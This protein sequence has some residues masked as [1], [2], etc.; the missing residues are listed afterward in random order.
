MDVRVLVDQ[1]NQ[2]TGQDK[3]RQT[4]I[5]R[6][7]PRLIECSIGEQ[8]MEFLIDSGAK[9]NT[10]SPEAYDRLLKYGRH[11]IVDHKAE[12]NDELRSYAASRPLKVICT[13]KADLSVPGSKRTARETEFYVIEG[14]SVSLLSFETSTELKLLRVG[15]EVFSVEKAE[16][17]QEF[18]KM[19]IPPIKIRT[20]NSQEP[21][22][23]YRYNIPL[24]MEAGVREKIREM[25]RNGI[26][27][28][29]EDPTWIS[30]MH[31]VPKGEDGF[32]ITIDYRDLN[33]TIPRDPFPMPITD[34]IMDK[35]RKAKK[36]SKYDL[37][38]AYHHIVLHRK[39]RK[40][41]AFM[42]DMG[43]MQWTRLP[44]GLSCAPELFQMIMENLFR[45]VEGVAVFLDDIL[46]YA[47]NIE[48]LRQR[49]E[50]VLE[51]IK[52][53]NLTLNQDKCEFE[54]DSIE[55]LGFKVDKDGFNP[56]DDKIK[57]VEAF[58]P[59]KSKK[60]LRSFLGLV[61]FLS[62]FI[63]NLSTMT[64]P[65]R[66]LLPK[67]EK[68]LW[69]SDQT[70]AFDEIKK[71]VATDIKKRGI[72][73]PALATELVTDASPVGLGAMLVQTAE[74]NE[75]RLIACASK[76][77]T[78]TE[79]KYPQT[80]REALAVVW[81]VEKFRYYL[82][83][84]NFTIVTDHEA[85]KFI[86]GKEARS[87]PGQI[88]S[89]AEGWALRLA[90]Y[91]FK[92]EFVA[93]EL[94]IA[95][96]AS[97]L[98]SQTDSESFDKAKS[99]HELFAVNLEKETQQKWLA[100]TWEQIFRA[101]ESDQEMALIA[102]SLEGN[103]RAWPEEI[104]KY[105]AFQDQ[106]AVREDGLIMKQEKLLLPKGLRTSAI[107]NAHTGHAGMSKMKNL[108]RKQVWWLGMDREVEEFV[109]KCVA[110]Q[111]TAGLPRPEPIEL[112]D[113]PEKPWDY[114]AI[115][116][117]SPDMSRHILVVTDC[118]S[119][120]LITVP[121]RK[122]DTEATKNVLN[123]IF[124]TYGLPK[125]I[126]SDNGAPFNAVELEEWL[127]R[128]GIKLI[129]STPW[130]PTENGLVERQNQGIK[131]ALR[132]AE[133]EKVCWEEALRTYTSA[134]NGWI[135]DTTLT[136]P[137]ELFFGRPL[138]GWLPHMTSEKE[139]KEDGEIRDNDRVKKFL[140]NMY[141]DK[142]RRARNSNIKVGDAVLVWNTRLR[143]GK[144]GF[145]S[146]KFKVVKREGGRL[147]VRDENG[148]EWIRSTKHA[149]KS[150]AEEKPEKSE[151]EAQDEPG[152]T[153]KKHWK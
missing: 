117:H 148:A 103:Q 73:D 22:Q 5:R 127:K 6:H 141:Q 39:S 136:A 84:L 42:T 78:G 137:S 138:R 153:S 97:R 75:K 121:M 62:P 12:V 96:P 134:Y 45:D 101:M 52:K 114:V 126:K 131:K 83:G 10:M 151:D 143:N 109:K 58:E 149:V 35:L 120:F 3:R 18:P 40:L 64:A 70:K 133:V 65:L 27:E 17:T 43:V 150:H 85:L 118:Y 147:T 98:V 56:S 80:Q 82:L 125:T 44:M 123:K 90:P 105:Q 146:K 7:D 33:R 72:F 95:D 59:P 115:D 55:F 81:G 144:G 30:A 21:V 37:R 11:A 77:L 13:F 68:Y 107:A 57:A 145:E 140:R 50:K 102:E 66:Q 23:A 89:R 116:F 71:A 47:E 51:I 8:R 124:N 54:K 19:P 110:C 93:G 79:Q 112:T 20:D 25:L 69:G 129:H 104:A 1:I 16:A 14:A 130:N 135:H 48:D 24:A 122:T 63:K 111:L 67:N 108:L 36:F 49:T 88:M 31:V 94:N 100:L 53:N 15:L 26:I 38:C 132:C 32:R 119:R 9:V 76:S 60:D 92:V 139:Q 46:V 86:Y 41:T 28:K 87:K 34:R 142:K 91:D 106:M 61:Q 4:K 152:D 2:I 74:G 29:A 99:P 113:L 128:L